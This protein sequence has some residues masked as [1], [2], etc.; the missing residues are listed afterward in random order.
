MK[1]V[2]ERMIPLRLLTPLHPQHSVVGMRGVESE[3]F[4]NSGVMSYDMMQSPEASMKQQKLGR[5]DGLAVG[6]IRAFPKLPPAQQR[7]L[8]ELLD[9]LGE[10]PVSPK[11][12]R[13]LQAT[14]EDFDRKTFWGLADLMMRKLDRRAR[15]AAS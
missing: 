1:S 5:G 11:E 10:G 15:R 12:K 9:K 14:L 3:Q 8:N 4:C 7:R 13:E 6:R 2:S